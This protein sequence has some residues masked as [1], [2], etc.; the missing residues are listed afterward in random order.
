MVA[1]T[2]SRAC[3]RAR[4]VIGYNWIVVMAINDPIS[5]D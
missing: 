2:P 4:A 1:N 5:L 3:H